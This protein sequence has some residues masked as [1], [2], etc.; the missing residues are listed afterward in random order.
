MEATGDDGQ[1]A[2][3][4]ADRARR[5]RPVPTMADRVDRAIERVAVDGPDA[6]PD[7]VLLEVTDISP[8]PVIVERLVRLLVGG[9]PLEAAFLQLGVSDDQRQR[10]VRAPSVMRA[11]EGG[12]EVRRHLVV[13]KALELADEAVETAADVMRNSESDKMQLQAAGMLL[14]V[15]GVDQGKPPDQT[16][17]QVNNYGD[18]A[19]AAWLERKKRLMAKAESRP[20]QIGATVDS[21]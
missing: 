21:E 15:A 20:T 3:A 6:L 14:K 8:Q 1:R 13:E 5:A 11:L 2:S 10:F 9:V 18:S 12:Q 4:D 17:V 19:S 7:R 16:L